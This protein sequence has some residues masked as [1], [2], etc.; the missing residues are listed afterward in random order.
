MPSFCHPNRRKNEPFTVVLID[1]RR[2]RDA[3]KATHKA[4]DAVVVV[5]GGGGECVYEIVCASARAHS[6]IQSNFLFEIIASRA[7]AQTLVC[8]R[9]EYGWPFKLDSEYELVG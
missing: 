1:N 3:N 4:V 2:A 9:V 6:A 5:G 8:V 7:L